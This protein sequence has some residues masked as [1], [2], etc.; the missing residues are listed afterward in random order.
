MIRCTSHFATRYLVSFDQASDRRGNTVEEK[1]RQVL[2]FDFGGGS[3][4]AILGSLRDGKLRMEE[5]YRFSNDPVM[6]NGTMYWDTL[7]HFHEIRQGILKA[8]QLGG[9]ESIGIDTWG[10]DFGLLDE[11][12]MLL[13]S[14]VHYRDD[15]TLGMQEEVFGKLSRE[16]I[17]D[18]TGNQFENFNT[19]FQLYSLVTRRPWILERADTLLLMPDLFNYFLT[20]VKKAEYTMASTTQLM[21]ARKK[22][23]SKEILSALHIPERILPDII[24]SGTVVGSLRAEICEELGVQPAK[25][26]AIAGH[27]TQSAV[28]SVPTQEKDF[29]FISCGTWSLFGTEL[30]GP[31][32][33][34]RSYA[35]NISNEGGYGQTTTLLKNII[36]LW[37]AQESRRQWQREGKE[38]SFGELEQLALTAEPFQSFIDPDDPRFVAAGNIPERIRQFC[39]ETDQRVPRTEAEIMCCINQSLAM[40]YRYALEQIE[41]CTGRHY[42]VIHMIGGGIQSRLLCQM[43]AGANGRKVI[44]GPTEATA[45]GNLAVQFMAL[46]EIADVAHARQIIADSETTYEYLP[47][48]TERW[49]AAYDKFVTYIQK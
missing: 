21:D 5:V 38:Y 27:D 43:T 33:D 2:A 48:D 6:L 44:A 31:V 12:G 26:I 23:W 4:R 19:I 1:K 16:E 37:L 3:G 47:Q 8:K 22:V 15:R 32:I 28:V 30:S 42:P 14:A 35:C 7:R 29:I 10:V 25:V 34:D 13:E 39:R 41:A 9:F 46:G 20:G 36:G 45:L 49:N 24:P 17:Y 11:H 18:L 40:K